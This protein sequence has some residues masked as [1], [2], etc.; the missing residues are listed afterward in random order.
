ME[1]TGAKRVMVEIKTGPDAS[2]ERERMILE[3]LYLVRRVASRFT[4][5]MNGCSKESLVSSGTIGLIKAVDNFDVSRSNNFIGYAIPMIV[6]EIKHFLRDR[7]WSVK[8]S[9]QL[10]KT[11]GRIGQAVDKKLA[12]L[13][14]YPTVAELGRELQLSEEVIIEGLEARNVYSPVSFGEE[15]EEGE[16]SRYASAQKIDAVNEGFRSIQEIE[17]RIEITRAVD[18]LSPTEQRII[19]LRFFEGKTQHQIAA[20]VRIS[21]MH[22]SRLLQKSLKAM[23]VH[24]N[25]R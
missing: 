19:I 3:N 7:G 18:R 17:D 8:I 5:L 9:R 25:G 6:G 14:R 1:K 13:G 15:Y 23:A 11:I 2:E 16:Q 22:V 24:I 12:Q 4:K 21:Q 20:I 10:H